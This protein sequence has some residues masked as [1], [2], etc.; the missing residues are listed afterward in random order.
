MVDDFS[1]AIWFFYDIFSYLDGSAATIEPDHVALSYGSVDPTTVP[2][3]IIPQPVSLPPASLP[4][5]NSLTPIMSSSFDDI[6]VQ[7]ALSNDAP[8]LR[9][10]YK[11]K[12]PSVKLRDFVTYT[13][14][15]KIP[16]PTSP[17]S[18]PS[19]G[20]RDAMQKEICALEDN[21]T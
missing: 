9:Q 1:R 12:F 4:P 18:E 6:M 13:A 3:L 5:A 21:D 2:P 14:I 15:K 10:W 8:D 7:G 16:S 19:T 17:A 11:E 20:R